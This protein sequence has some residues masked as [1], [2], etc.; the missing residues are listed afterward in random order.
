MYGQKN[1]WEAAVLIPA[2][3]ASNQQRA[4]KQVWPFPGI[5]VNDAV[6]TPDTGKPKD[7]GH[8]KQV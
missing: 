3:M 8:N 5:A 2:T 7:T 6:S 4:G 1:L